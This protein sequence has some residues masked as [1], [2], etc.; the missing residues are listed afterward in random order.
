MVGV[1][2]LTLIHVEVSDVGSWQQLFSHR[3]QRL[4]AAV[5][6]E[7]LIMHPAVHVLFTWERGCILGLDHMGLVQHNCEPLVG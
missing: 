1:A 3:R 6:V 5:D 2:K 4:H 7:I